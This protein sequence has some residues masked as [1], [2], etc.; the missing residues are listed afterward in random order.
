MPANS[1]KNFTIVEEINGKNKDNK[2][3]WNG[4]KQLQ[5]LV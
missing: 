3:N 4:K 2:I 5:Q 1:S